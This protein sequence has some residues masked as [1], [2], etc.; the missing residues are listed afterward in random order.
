MITDSY[1]ET[2]NRQ[3]EKTRAIFASLKASGKFPQAKVWQ[4]V[5]Q[6]RIYTGYKSEYI[7]VTPDL[8]VIKCR[9]NMSWSQIIDE[10][11]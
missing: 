7:E 8:D 5:N 11:I 9:T 3:F 6:M 10:I 1:N 2:Y 4:C